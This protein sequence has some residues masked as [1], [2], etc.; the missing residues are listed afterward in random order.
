MSKSLTSAGEHIHAQNLCMYVRMHGHACA[1]V[2][3]SMS[4]THILMDI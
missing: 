1:C 2:C 4:Y 3:S